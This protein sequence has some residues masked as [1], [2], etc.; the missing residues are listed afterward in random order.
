[1][2][3]KFR[4]LFVLICFLSLTIFSQNDSK[5]SIYNLNPLNY[6]PAY[7]G[8]SDGLY[9]IGIYSSQW[10]GFEGAPKTQ[11]LAIDTN[12]ENK[13]IGV[14]I[15]LNNDQSGAALTTN[16][17]SNFSYSVNLNSKI[18]T[19][20]GT[21]IGYN[22]S[23]IDLDLLKRLNPEESVFG[24]DKI[25]N[26]SLLVGLGL[27]I[28]T[29]NFF[30]GI[31]SPNILT[32]KYYDPSFKGVIATKRNYFYTTIGYKFNKNREIEFTPTLLVR[33]TAGA[34]I[35]TLVSL[36]LNW[37]NK[38]LAG[39]NFEPG[40]TIGAYTGFSV[41]KGIKA[42]YAYDRSLRNFSRYNNGSHTFFINYY[43]ENNSS[44]KCSCKLF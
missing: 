14:G 17:E 42:G 13:K 40:A 33:T 32:K 44:D 30:F 37:Q 5:L 43:L 1:M 18:K 4:F 20:F 22:S 21:K 8:S 24:Y 27:N 36:N 6:N 15:N 10:V 9:L 2:N 26:N 38:M 28:F 23:R 29:D 19:T 16:L 12:L 7:A 25:V 39:L 3:N 35:S 31:A 11:Y 41:F 34:K